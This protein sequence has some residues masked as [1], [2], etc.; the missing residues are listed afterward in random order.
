MDKKLEA[1]IARLE[2]LM[3]R[4]NEQQ[5]DVVEAIWD[6][7]KQIDEL[8][9]PLEDLLKSDRNNNA[10]SEIDNALSECDYI[11]PKAWLLRLKQINNARINKFR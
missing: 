2:K 4:K 1:R 10:P 6:T 8:C 7:A 5:V 11:L 9:R 3:C